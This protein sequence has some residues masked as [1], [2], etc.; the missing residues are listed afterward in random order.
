MNIKHHKISMTVEATTITDGLTDKEIQDAIR[1]E[2]KEGNQKLVYKDF[3]MQIRQSDIEHVT[4]RDGKV[5]YPE[6]GN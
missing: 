1:A 2:L 3:P 6:S 4:V 5:I